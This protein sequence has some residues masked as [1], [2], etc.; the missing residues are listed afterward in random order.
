MFLYCGASGLTFRA[1]CNTINTMEV[2][3]PQ[4]LW[5]DYNR[6]A[7]P[8]DVSVV[9]SFQE[10]DVKIER[11]Y[12][13]GER[14][15]DGVTRI[16]ARL[17][18]PKVQ[19]PPVII[20]MNEL[21]A[22]VDECDCLP[23]AKLGYAVLV[24]DYAGERDDRER[25]T[26]YPKALDFANYFKHPETA[27]TFPANPK[28]S[29][30][31]IWMTVLMRAI[32]F[33]EE[34]KR[35]SDTMAVMGVGE[36]GSQVFKIA[37][38]E[39]LKCGVTM[40]STHE[41]EPKADDLAFRTCLDNSG[42]AKMCRF[43]ILNAVCS[44]DHDGYFDRISATCRNVDKYYLTT[45]QRVSK[46]LLSR[47]KNCIKRW[48]N[49][50]LQMG[51]PL[52]IKPPEI[53]AK[54][55]DRQLYYT[56]KADTRENIV[57]VDLFVAYSMKVGAFR[58]WRH[59]P[60]LTAAVGEYIAKVPVYDASRPVYAFASVTYVDGNTFSTPLL[61]CTPALLGIKEHNIVK[62]RLLYDSDSGTDDFVSP[63]GGDEAVV[64]RGGAYGIEG[65]CSLSGELATYKFSDI[66]FKAEPDSVLQLI[67]YSDVEQELSFSVRTE[68]DDGDVEYVC[69]KKLE[70]DNNWTK[71]TLSADEFKS[72]EGALYS[73]ADAIYFSVRGE[74]L[75]VNTMLWV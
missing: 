52:D 67:V 60:T 75:L 41:P 24:L 58:N 53:F 42:Y 25:Y 15:A 70:K 36:G 4:G 46:A 34:D 63:Q 23:L 10:D 33:V 39:D 61:T 57:K 9:T 31:Y 21:G 7:L 40:F 48:L 49:R 71:F 43:P 27:D 69:V 68:E 29:C 17:W 22:C 37:A 20:L 11:L 38:L 26:L 64:M 1:F 59:I 74:K 2:L 45:G 47:Q 8:L 56:V 13:S 50:Y 18:I 54:E 55:S 16:Y 30:R 32:T 65:V 3:T 73:F 14:T 72:C 66:Q 5:K 44:N 19:D 35:L 51:L 6:K 62:S 28:Q 12:F